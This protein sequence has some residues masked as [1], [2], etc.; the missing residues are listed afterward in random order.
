[1]LFK[2][3]IR[4]VPSSGADYFENDYSLNL[5]SKAL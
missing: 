1:M 2:F 4:R 3:F 5:L